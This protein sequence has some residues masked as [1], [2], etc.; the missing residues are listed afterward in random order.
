MMNQRHTGAAWRRTARLVST[1]LLCSLVFGVSGC[2]MLGLSSD[3][4]QQPTTPQPKKKAK[5]KKAADKKVADAKGGDNKKAKGS[6]EEY[7]RPEY[8]ENMRRNPF[9]PD[10]DVLA[11]VGVTVIEETR[12][13]EPL[14]KYS[15]SQLELVAIISEVAVPKAMFIDPDG[16]GHL[17]KEG[18]RIGRQGG[19]VKDIRDNEVDVLETTGEDENAQ[20]SVRTIRLTDTE[21]RQV[22]EN[23]EELSGAEREALERLLRDPEARKELRSSLR[24]RALE[25]GASERE[26]RRKTNS[27]GI[28]PPVP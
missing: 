16:F 11:P 22:E 9:A 13:F 19:T 3:A 21:I 14:E 10:P 20:S 28:A 5:K 12:K 27:S 2:E 24:E 26:Q 15:I 7:E 18:D 1:A 8:P 4:G 23:S 17:I 25:A 6:D